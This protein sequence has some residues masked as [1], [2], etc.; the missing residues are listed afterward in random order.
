MQGFE[1]VVD[2]AD[3]AAE[4]GTSGK[5]ASLAD[6]S[7][8]KTHDSLHFLL[9]ALTEQRHAEPASPAR[10]MMQLPRSGTGARRFSSME[11][12]PRSPVQ[13]M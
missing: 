8:K 10:T 5:E 3:L 6:H 7:L 12:I 2:E 1:E 13:D 4:F 11:T 9:S